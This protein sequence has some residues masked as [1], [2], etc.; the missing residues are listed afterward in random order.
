MSDDAVPAEAALGHG[1][2]FEDL[3]PGMEASYSKV[4]TAEDVDRFAVLS[5]DV[6]PVHVDEGFAATTMFKKRIAHGFLTGALISTVLGTKLPGPGC[7]YLSQDMKFRAPVY[8][9]DEVTATVKIA[10]LDAAKSR[11]VLDCACTVNGKPVITGQAV[12]M[13][14]RKE[15]A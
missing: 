4:I 8:L 6:N 11:V 14:D 1:Y 9:G 5:G 7:I 13:V 3:S 10:S 15:Q 12:V 2:Y